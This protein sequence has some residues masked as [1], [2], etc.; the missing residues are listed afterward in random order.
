MRSRHAPRIDIGLSELNQACAG[1]F[2]QLGRPPPAR[3][4]EGLCTDTPRAHATPAQL[5]RQ[6]IGFGLHARA[7]D[8]HHHRGHAR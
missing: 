1:Q 7:H 5:A 6:A 4:A 8:R 3:L 2:E